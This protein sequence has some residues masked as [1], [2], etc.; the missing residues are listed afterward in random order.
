MTKF[1]VLL[2]T[3]NGAENACVP[4]K[5]DSNLLPLVA[6]CILCLLGLVGVVLWLRGHRLPK[7]LLQKNPFNVLK[8][9]DSGMLKVIWANWQI[10]STIQWNL[11]VTFGPPFSS[12]L[13]I[14][15]LM[16]LDFLS[17]DW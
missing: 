12:L 4:C 2:S 8:H 3:F 16:Q 13:D 6:A 15:S 7:W 11:S 5:S 14:L 17:L 10:V 9:L 1:A